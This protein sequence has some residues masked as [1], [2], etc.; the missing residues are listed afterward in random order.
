M[1]K[2]EEELDTYSFNIKFLTFAEKENIKN[3]YVS[4]KKVLD[5]KIFIENLTKENIRIFN[6]KYMEKDITTSSTLH[7]INCNNTTAVISS[8]INH[9]TIQ[10]C[11]NFH[12]KTLGGVISGIDSITSSNLTIIIENEPIYFVDSSDSHYCNFYISENVVVDTIIM[13]YCS[14]G[15]SIIITKD[16]I[17]VIKYKFIPPRSFF[18]IY[19]IYMF[20][21]INDNL[22]LYYFVPN[23]KDKKIIN[24]EI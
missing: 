9:I 19:R 17:G 1:E 24:A 11:N 20:N 10:N 6:G 3:L 14:T 5:N 23:K 15:L 16:I 7:F 22:E 12:I 21:V 18:D 4:W 13:S 2:L 8:K